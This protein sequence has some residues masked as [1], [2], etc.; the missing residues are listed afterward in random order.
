MDIIWL[1][2]IGIIVIGFA[3]VAYN[4]FIEPSSPA[5][6]SSVPNIN[7]KTLT[8]LPVQTDVRNIISTFCDIVHDIDVAMSPYAD[9]SD[10]KLSINGGSSSAEAYIHCWYDK[11]FFGVENV[12]KD[13]LNRSG[14]YSTEKD[15]EGKDGWF[16]NN[17]E[18]INFKSKNV[19]GFDSMIESAM[20]NAGTLKVDIQNIISGILPNHV[21]TD[22]SVTIY[23]DKHMSFIIRAN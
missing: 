12:L 8:P 22:C 13:K 23:D 17:N 3:Y 5:K 18:W 20:G 21:I 1:A 4:K 19:T 10:S 9:S 6:S 16:I 15:A 7:D 14:F 2:L 11:D